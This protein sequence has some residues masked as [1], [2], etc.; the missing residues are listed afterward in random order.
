MNEPDLRDAA[1]LAL[2]EWRDAAR[3]LALGFDSGDDA[4]V[5]RRRRARSDE[6]AEPPTSPEALQPG[7]RIGHFTLSRFIARGGMGQVWVAFDEE[8]RRKVALKLLL[9]DRIDERSLQLFTREARAGG[10]LNHPNLVTTLAYGTDDGLAWIAQELVEG[11]WTVKDSLD[12]LRAEASVPKGYYREVAEFVAKIA[13]GI[14]AIHDAGVIHRDLKPQNILIAD[15]DTPKVTDFGLAR[16]TDDSVHSQSGDFAGTWAYM[17]P[18][19]V[20]AKRMGL[21]HRTDVFSLGVV[22]YE[23]LA[24]RRPFDGDTTHQIAEKILTHDPPEASKVRSQ[25]PRELAVICGKALEKAPGRRYQSAAEMAADL[26]RHLRD[27]PIVARPSGRMARLAKQVKRH[28]SL[29]SAVGIGAL[30]LLLV[31]ALSLRLAGRT[32]EL[33][34][35]SD[36]LRRQT[37]LAR[38]NEAAANRAADDL[39]AEVDRSEARRIVAESLS[40]SHEDPGLGVLL[41]LEAHGRGEPSALNAV[42]SSLDQLYER[43]RLSARGGRVLDAALDPNHRILAALPTGRVLER[44]LDRS[45]PAEAFRI[46]PAA[47]ALF[48]P[49][50]TLLAVA[51]EGGGLEVHETGQGRRLW[52]RKTP[53]RGLVFSDDGR[54]LYRRPDRSSWQ[55]PIAPEAWDARTGQPVAFQGDLRC[56]DLAMVGTVAAVQVGRVAQAFRIP[57][58]SPLGS[59]STG[60]LGARLALSPAGKRL[61]VAEDGDASILLLGTAADQPVAP[62]TLHTSRYAAGRFIDEDHVVVDSTATGTGMIVP[63]TRVHR[64]E[65]GEQLFNLNA[66]EAVDGQVHLISDLDLFVVSNHDRFLRLLDSQGRVRA[67]LMGHA[68]RIVEVGAPGA[69]GLFWSRD[70][71]GTVIVWSD[72]PAGARVIDGWGMGL[73]RFS[74]DGT[75]LAIH[76]SSRWDESI[77]VVDLG[78]G[79][80]RGRAGVIPVERDGSTKVRGLRWLDGSSLELTDSTWQRVSVPVLKGAAARQPAAAS[81]PAYP[82]AFRTTSEGYALIESDVDGSI[83]VVDRQTRQLCGTLPPEDA[84]ELRSAEQVELRADHLHARSGRSVSIWS[85]GQGRLEARFDVP[86]GML[87][88]GGWGPRTLLAREQ[89]DPWVHDVL[90]WEAGSPEPV[91]IGSVPFVRSQS[92]V[93]DGYAACVSGARVRVLD[94]ETLAWSREMSVTIG[95]F[96]WTAGDGMRDVRSVDVHREAGLVAATIDS[97]CHVWDLNP[98]RAARRDLSRALSLAELEAHRLAPRASLEFAREQLGIG[99]SIDALEA[100]LRSEGVTE[101]VIEA[102][103]LEWVVSR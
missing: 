38:G 91:R 32:R 45:R 73:T 24:L 44:R 95:R 13:D 6:G 33:Q 55:E 60:S 50:G 75:A 11:S 76:S 23:L 80:P 43:A 21:D 103:M 30:A 71:S 68:D 20:A 29:S 48:S 90:V 64:A 36:D 63:Y 10:R 101:D 19:Q 8:L 96:A 41:G 46:A 100:S 15:D 2:E 81:G 57:D 70:V 9:P 12:G 86:D 97:R 18:E 5:F 77:R 94:L 83:S 34:R 26:R 52:R 74:P 78:E 93:R 102:A 82:A 22:L 7:R 1:Q 56:A 47:E 72:Q 37:E 14:Q 69:G 25:C 17:S 62:V 92:L 3:L 61:L 88:V 87:I 40:A 98:F 16:V 58:L 65:S 31:T 28:P 99:T 49:D 27:E 67:T 89:D 84:D 51:T 59:L 39:A 53:I 42:W 85:L 66:L 35:T 4:S 54:W 79:G